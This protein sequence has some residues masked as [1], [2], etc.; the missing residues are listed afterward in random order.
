MNILYLRQA[1]VAG[2]AVHFTGLVKVGD[3]AVRVLLDEEHD[4]RAIWSHKLIEPRPLVRTGWAAGELAAV[5]A[6]HRARLAADGQ[7]VSLRRKLLMHET[8]YRRTG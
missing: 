5:A 4:S 1:H 6:Q 3:C 8:R 2:R 7:Q